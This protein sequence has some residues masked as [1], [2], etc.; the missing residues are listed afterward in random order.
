MSTASS[1]LDLRVPDETGDWK[2][3]AIKGRGYIGGLALALMA[4]S[5]GT[6]SAQTVGPP[7]VVPDAITVNVATSITV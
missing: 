7:S 2:A 1:A 5:Y 4:S 6:T 3:L